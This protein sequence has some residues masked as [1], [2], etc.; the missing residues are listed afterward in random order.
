MIAE[1]FKIIL[2][3]HPVI[4]TI[5]LYGPQL[6]GDTQAV[7]TS[8]YLS[9]LGR[10]WGTDNCD[11]LGSEKI[12]I[13]PERRERFAQGILDMDYITEI[14]LPRNDMI[15]MSYDLLFD[16]DPPIG[17]IRIE[18]FEAF[19]EPIINT[20]FRNFIKAEQLGIIKKSKRF[21]EIN[22]KGVVEISE[23]SNE[24]DGC[25]WL[26]LD[27]LKIGPSNN[28]LTYHA[29]YFLNRLGR[30]KVNSK[31]IASLLASHYLFEKSRIEE[32]IVDMWSSRKRYSES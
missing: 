29:I 22:R 32:L 27:C 6:V 25:E 23:F 16:R 21:G 7:N 8:Q 19:S 15:K 5:Y 3:Q 26:D 20:L 9:R 31:S 13:S 1:E 18:G 14:S 10:D 17:S 2:A 30:Y 4:P 11:V 24:F 28:L 12:S